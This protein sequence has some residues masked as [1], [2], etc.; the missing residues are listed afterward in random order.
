MDKRGKGDKGKGG[1]SRSFS[2]FDVKP[3]EESENAWKPAA[4]TKEQLDALE[5]LL[6]TTKGL[7]NKFTPEKFE[8][9]TDQFLELEI[10][11]RTD[12][13]AI[14][15]MVFD[16]A[17]FEPI[18]G[19]MYS[20]LC[21]RCAEKFPEFPDENNPEAKPHTFKRLLL[22]KC[23]EE[24]EKENVV[25]EEIKGLPEDCPEEEKEMKR[26]KAKNRMLG[27]IRFIGE[28]YKCKMLTEKI[29]HECVIKL[30]G[31]VAN[32]DLDEVECLVK[33]L[34]A[35]GKLIDHPKS[36]EYMDAYFLRIREMAINS[37]LPNR[38]RFMLQEL[39]E[40][41]KGQWKERKVD[42]NLRAQ[43]AA[44]AGNDAGG[45]GPEGAKGSGDARGGSGDAR[46]QQGRGD[47]RNE[48]GNKGGGKGGAS[49][50]AR[51]RAPARRRHGGG[52]QQLPAAAGGGRG[53]SGDARAGGAGG[54]SG[55]ADSPA[56]SAAPVALT[57]DQ[58]EKKLQDNLEEFFNVGDGK[59]LIACLKE[60]AP[61]LPEGR[62]DSLGFSL[63]GIAM[64]KAC[65]ARTDGP[66]DRACDLF[67]IL[68]TASLVTSDEIK[69]Y[70]TDMLEF[71]E[72]EVCDVPHIAY[73]YS[74][75]LAAAVAAKLIDLAFLPTAL[76]PLVEA[77]LVK[78]DAAILGKY[79]GAAWIFVDV[80]RQLKLMD[81]VGEGAKAFMRRPSP[82]SPRY[83]QTAERRP[84]RSYCPLVTS[85]LSTPL[86]ARRSKRRRRRQHRRRRRPSWVLLRSILPLAY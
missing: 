44:A 77:S 3:L 52:Q 73:Y 53:G 45:K 22:N 61:K 32:P 13:I 83:S 37:T 39:I 30:L 81:G 74:R 66:R 27:N 78:P 21:V 31:D 57:E 86:W 14:I 72:D 60:L 56:P 7:L 11:C 38:V 40:L 59:E 65:D 69:Q 8:K 49:G 46:I 70:F 15:D 58:L 62:T 47:V 33:L 17:L 79:A 9:L 54:R 48:M 35:I 84:L 36:K 75:F 16:K 4:K 23:Q 34:T 63:L 43:S 6:R 29:M 71:L 41:R 19:Y 24:F 82:M 26:K 18:F 85:P 55:R 28:L 10:T 50:D 80:L 51:E 68:A 1:P 42:A 20:Q 67:G 64:P 2:N 76:K 12:M 25:E 5:V